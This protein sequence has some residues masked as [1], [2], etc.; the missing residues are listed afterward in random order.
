MPKK[1]EMV[2]KHGTVIKLT[3]KCEAAAKR[4]RTHIY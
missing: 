2:G 3:A 4:M 1:Q